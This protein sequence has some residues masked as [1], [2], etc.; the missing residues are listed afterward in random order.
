MLHGIGGRTIAEAKRNMSVV[1]FY[2]WCA[3]INARGTINV[4]EKL[5]SVGA[6]IT[7]MLTNSGMQQLKKRDGTP[8]TIADFMPHAGPPIEQ[9]TEAGELTMQQV[10]AVLGGGVKR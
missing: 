5:E 7:W 10:L 6:L 9:E 1:E 3:Y 4:A 8:F 2:H